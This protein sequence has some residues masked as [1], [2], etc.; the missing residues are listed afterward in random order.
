LTRGAR[1]YL[2]GLAPRGP[3]RA[4]SRDISISRF[5]EENAETP[6]SRRPAASQTREILMLAYKT[7]RLTLGAL[8]FGLLAFSA[9]NLAAQAV[10]PDHLTTAD[11]YIFHPPIKVENNL[12]GEPAS[13]YV[14]AATDPHPGDLHATV[15]CGSFL[16]QLLKNTYSTLTDAVL[17][18]LT[19]TTAGG[20]DGSSS[21]NAQQWY[22]AI[23]HGYTVSG[24]HFV[25]RTSVTQIAPGDILASAYT[26]SGDTGH[27]M[28][29]Q[30]ITFHDAYINPPMTISGVTK[31]DRYWVTV[32]DS[33]KDP[34]GNDWASNPFPDS[35]D[36]GAV[37]DTGIGFGAIALYA[38]ADDEADPN[39]AAP[40]DAGKIV[41]WAWNVSPTTSSVYYAVPKPVGATQGYRPIEA[42]RLTGL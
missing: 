25:Q 7:R 13:I 38:L 24:I 6:D 14:E 11:T 36:K 26:T 8:A 5:I 17:R 3:E 28:T 39:N 18:G 9:Q 37:D 29:V 23:Q 32:F 42:G 21:P 4:V 40:A 41:A 31:V 20:T 1:K 27:A 15:K 2:D 35:R 12:W 34:H 22:S 19:A 16:A 30:S 33:S 10:W